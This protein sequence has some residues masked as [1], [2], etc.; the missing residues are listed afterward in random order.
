MLLYV[1]MVLLNNHT[2]DKHIPSLKWHGILLCLHLAV[3]IYASSSSIL[4]WL[5]QKLF[6]RTV[7]M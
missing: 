7:C 4:L 3:E 6:Y 2:H 5:V 1:N